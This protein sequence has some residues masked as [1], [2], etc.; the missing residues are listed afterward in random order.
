MSG[1]LGQFH[2]AWQT[3]VQNFFTEVIEFQHYVVAIG[4]ATVAGDD[5][6]NHRASK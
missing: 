6:F 4:T 3:A 1:C 5:F 2:D